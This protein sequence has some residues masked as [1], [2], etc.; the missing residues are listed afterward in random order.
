MFYISI[1]HEVNLNGLDLN[2]LPPLEALLR[3]KNVTFAAADAGMSQPAMSRALG[4]LRAIFDDPLLVRGARGLAL[5]PK[6]LDLAVALRPALERVKEVFRAPNFDPKT[7]QRT[8]RFASSDVHNTLIFPTLLRNLADRAPGL[9]LSCEPYGPDL[10]ERM[11]SGDLDFAF[12]L[13][14]SPL[15]TGVK[16]VYLAQ[17]E[18]ALVM[19]RNH[20][21]AERDWTLSDYATVPHILIKL[22]NDGVNDLD[23]RLAV[24]GIQRRTL[25]STPHFLDA[26]AAASATDAVTTLS[27]AFAARFA[28]QF[29]LI[30]HRP[31]LDSPSFG[32]VLVMTQARG[33]D[34]LMA[35]VAEQ[36]KLAATEVYAPTEG[37][38][39]HENR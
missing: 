11:A 19:R 15:P 21:L 10:R 29:D 38:S 4:R 17:D 2:L 5:T 24:H 3:R 8:I 18:L 39:N 35:W 25:W 1:M 31:P 7:A 34:P 14:N 22:L 12:A 30:L 9:D 26:L 37:S 33:L 28:N 23:A 32:I 20:P 6:A 13:D 27:R 36:V 16:S